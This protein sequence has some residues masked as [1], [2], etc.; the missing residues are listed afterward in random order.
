MKMLTARHTKVG[1]V[2]AVC[3]LCLG[4]A[5]YG[6]SGG[7]VDMPCA[8]C[9]V[10]TQSCMPLLPRFG[11]CEPTRRGGRHGSIDKNIFFVPTVCIIV[12]VTTTGQR[13]NL[14]ESGI[15]PVEKDISPVF[16]V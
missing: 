14:R 10:L 15:P 4:I 3:P 5:I 7:A 6:T 12:P 2:N 1:C 8:K 16:G 11:D 13:D 9:C